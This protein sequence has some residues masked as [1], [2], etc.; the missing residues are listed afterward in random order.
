MDT[1]GLSRRRLLGLAGA[2]ALASALAACSSSAPA[3]TAAPA[4]PTTAP[5]APT[6]SAAAAPTTAP[7]TPTTAAAAN[8]QPSPAMTAASTSQGPVTVTEMAIRGEWPKDSVINAWSEANKVKINFVN[9]DLVHM[10]AMTAAGNP[11]DM[12]RC[13]AADVPYF[14]TLK[15]VQ[16]LTPYFQQ[17]KALAADNLAPSNKAYW[18][19][20]LQPGFGQIYGMVKDWSPDLSL[21]LN[22]QIFQEQGVPVPSADTVLTYDQLYSMSKSLTKRAGARTLIRGYGGSGHDWWDRQVE[23]MLNT[24][25]KSMWPADFGTLAWD[26]SEAR[27]VLQYWFTMLKEDLT[28]NPLDPAPAWA[29]QNFVDGQLAICQYGYWFSGMVNGSKVQDNTLMLS[30]PKWGP[31]HMDPTITATGDMIHSH[32]KVFDGVWKV[33]DWFHTGEPAMERAQ[34][35]WGVPALKSLYQYMP[36]QNPFQKQVSQIVQGDLQISG[37]AVRYNPYID[38][39][40]NVAQNPI[41][42]AWEKNLEPALKGQMTFDQLI[43]AVESS[44]NDAIKNGKVGMG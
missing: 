17:T 9:Y 20:G 26:T 34:S 23:V 10:I 31:Q 28:N 24:E 36:T 7:A 27:S 13:Q 42:S 32:T 12:F 6:S 4:A 33:F 2:A 38:Q 30:A 8:A 11:P 1:S 44:V 3:P 39:S 21:Y 25:G 35:G 37:F 40:E 41:L 14:L 5:A 19:S 18:Y 22:K 16:D 15:M 43:K 29:G